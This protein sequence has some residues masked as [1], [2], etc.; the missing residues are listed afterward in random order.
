MPDAEGTGNHRVEASRSAARPT[1]EVRHPDDQD[2]PDEGPAMSG[3]GAMPAGNAMD[4][5]ATAM[6]SPDATKPGSMPNTESTPLPG[7]T[8][9][10]IPVLR[11][12]GAVTCGSAPCAT[13]QA[14]PGSDR[15]ARVLHGEA[16]PSLDAERPAAGC[17]APLPAVCCGIRSGS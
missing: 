1:P 15:R 12:A 3:T 2:Q 5:W 4:H 6:P 8:E 11:D 10:R 9:E 17:G 16:F 14:R 7:E 13:P